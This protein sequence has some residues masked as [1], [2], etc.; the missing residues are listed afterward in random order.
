MEL[1]LTLPQVIERVFRQ[2]TRFMA[3][4]RSCW[5]FFT[6]FAD[7]ALLLRYPV[8]GDRSFADFLCKST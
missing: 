2:S 1:A 7:S 5:Q 6:E 3:Q 4:T 8:S